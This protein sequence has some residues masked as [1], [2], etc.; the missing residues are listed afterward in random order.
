MRKSRHTYSLDQLQEAVND[1]VS[2]AQVLKKLGLKVSGSNY[3][4][5]KR[6]IKN[7]NIDDSH[8]TGQ[9]WNV[10]KTFDPRPKKK[11]ENILSGEISY[12]NSNKLRKRLIEE[13]YFEHKCYNCKN[14][15][16]NG[17]PIPLELEHKNGVHTDN[18]LENLTLLCPNCHAQTK[19]YRGKNI[20]PDLKFNLTEDELNKLLWKMPLN[21]IAKYYGVSKQTIIQICNNLKLDRPSI[22]YWTN[23]KAKA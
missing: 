2:V 1:S 7:N 12:V 17:Q 6:N 20:N 3:D 9:G 14:K 18:R 23:K 15:T 8:F 21:D 11:L 4:T 13:N 10:G 5:I 16:W 22:G 19:T